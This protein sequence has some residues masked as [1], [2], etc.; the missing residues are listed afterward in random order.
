MNPRITA[1]IPQ[2]DH[3]LELTFTN[4]ELRCFDVAPY[5]NKGIFTELNDADYFNQ[6]RVNM[7]TVEWP[8]G[9]DFCP[10]TLYEDSMV[11]SEE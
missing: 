4:G 8:N 11:L 6:P 2:E 10:D 5:L 1:V 3:T 9:Q 7:G